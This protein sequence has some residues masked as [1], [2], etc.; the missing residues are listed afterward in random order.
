MKL[1]MAQRKTKRNTKSNYSKTIEKESKLIAQYALK[2]EKAKERKVFTINKIFAEVK[3]NPKKYQLVLR[4]GKTSR[5]IK[6]D[7]RTMAKIRLGIMN[8]DPNAM[9]GVAGPKCK[10]RNFSDPDCFCLWCNR[11][12]SGPCNCTALCR[13]RM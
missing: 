7:I 13:L 8:E 2:I 5:K 12:S 10:C 1:D 6:P 11:K 4:T 9:A 3:R